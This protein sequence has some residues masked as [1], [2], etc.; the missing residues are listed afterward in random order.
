MVADIAKLSLAGDASVDSP[1]IR[2]RKKKGVSVDSPN[3]EHVSVN[4]DH[5]LKHV[6]VDSPVDG[7]NSPPKAAV[8]S[9][10]KRNAKHV[11]VDSP[12]DG[13][14]SPPKAAVQSKSK[15]NAGEKPPPGPVL[16]PPSTRN[17]RK[18]GKYLDYQ[19]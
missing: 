14:N 5:Q 4:L 10:S 6:S 2:P 19:L 8:K 9:K 1:N 12:V 15:K 18:P 11:S 17:T 7:P 3:I 13:P 16:R